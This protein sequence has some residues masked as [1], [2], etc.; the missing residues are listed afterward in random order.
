MGKLAHEIKSLDPIKNGLHVV[1]DSEHI[2]IHSILMG[3]LDDIKR[4]CDKH[5]IKWGISG[6]CALGAIRHKGFIPWDDDVD[7]YFSREEFEKFR[8]IYP[9]EKKEQYEFLCPGDEKYYVHLPRVFDNNT[10][11]E[12]IQ[13]LERGKGLCIDIFVL[14]N[15]YDNKV[16]RT[17]HGVECTLYLFILSCVITRSQ[18]S[19]LDQYGSKGLKK[20]TRIRSIFGSFFSY[21]SIEKWLTQAVK[22]F[23]K[24][25]NNHSKYVVSVTGGGHYFG[26]LYPRDIMCNYQEREFENR[27]Y[28]FMSDIVYFCEMR[29]GKNYM[30]LPPEDKREKQVYVKLDLDQ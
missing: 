15:T 9:K 17:L 2:R 6:G 1:S 14:E 19:V 26:E 23:S 29:Y 12:L 28:P 16:M 5:N 3:M 21:R 8:S 20:A 30:Q 24:V 22:C 27:V 18:R 11:A 10:T 13:K 7:I 4:V 25:K